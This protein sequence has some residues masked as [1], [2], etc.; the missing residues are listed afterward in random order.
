MPGT[1]SSRSVGNSRAEAIAVTV[2]NDNAASRAKAKSVLIHGYGNP[3]RQD[4]GLGPALVERLERWAAE[5]PC[6]GLV[7][8]S[9]YQLNAEDALEVSRH[10]E[11]IFVDAAR[12]GEAPFTVIPLSADPAITFSTHAMAPGAVLALCEELYGKRPKASMLAIR[13]YA[14]EPNAPM[15]PTSR[16]NLEAAVDYVRRR[17]AP[18][19]DSL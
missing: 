3:G 14:W 9:S 6:A 7:L 13:G 11:V 10:D 19:S 4:D 17:L 8:D 1:N 5:H 2:P 12:E 16:E 18:A 15:T